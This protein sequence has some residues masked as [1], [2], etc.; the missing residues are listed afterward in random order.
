[1]SSTVNNGAASMPSP[2]D[3][4]NGFPQPGASSGAWPRAEEELRAAEP[5]LVK[6]AHREILDHERKRRVE[7]KCMELQEMMEEQGYSEEEIRQKVGTFRQMLMEKEGVLT[8]EDRPGGH[9]VTLNPHLSGQKQGQKQPQF[10]PEDGSETC[11]SPPSMRHTHNGIYKRKWWK[12]AKPERPPKFKNRKKR[13]HQH[14]S[15][16]FQMGR[17]CACGSSS[18]LRKKK[19]TGKK[20]RRDRS[21]SG[22]RRKRRHRTEAVMGESCGKGRRDRVLPLLHPPTPDPGP[23]TRAQ[24]SALQ[25]CPP[26]TLLLWETHIL[27]PGGTEL[28]S[29]GSERRA[30]KPTGT[31]GRRSCAVEPAPESSLGWDVSFG[32]ALQRSSSEAERLFTKESISFPNSWRACPKADTRRQQHP[33]PSGAMATPH[34]A[35]PEG[36]V[37]GAWA[38]GDHG[39]RTYRRRK[40]LALAQPA[41][42]PR[43]PSRDW[44]VA[45]PQTSGLSSKHQAREEGGEVYVMF[46]VITW[47]RR[48]QES[49]HGGDREGIKTNPPEAQ[50]A[51]YT[52]SPAPVLTPEAGPGAFTYSEHSPQPRWCWEGR[53]GSRS[54]ARSLSMM[55]GESPDQRS[56]TPGFGP[57]PRNSVSSSPERQSGATDSSTALCRAGK[58]RKMYSR[59]EDDQ[60]DIL[61]Q[62]RSGSARKRP[63][64]YYRP[65][66]SSS[67]SCL[68]SDYSSR[69]HSH[70]SYSSRSRGTRSHTRS[71]S[72]TP[73]PS[74]HS[75]SSSESGGF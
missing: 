56:R 32:T 9:M 71:P 13:Q 26:P 44:G 75:R 53:Q 50:W 33:P 12:K 47:L 11:D 61:N 52:A 63:I 8:R 24:T 22:S 6:R 2:P 25:A 62:H 58:Q 39:G 16:H 23:R 45:P 36:A 55:R 18:P 15:L 1:M 7:L 67:S 51:S 34:M 72:R 42:C 59:D 27:S 65:S 3:A 19:K 17:G 70:G 21:D 28:E 49:G 43:R 4:S 68:S 48:I 10:S 74:Y 57:G 41:D 20:H 30:D 37:A 31:E 29:G 64:P 69:S 35:L 66:P 54:S 40:G 5:G 14:E 73:S 38:G 46:P 60:A